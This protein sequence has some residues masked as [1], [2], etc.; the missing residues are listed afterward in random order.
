MMTRGRYQFSAQFTD[1]DGLNH[2][3]HAI[4]TMQ[5]VA[6]FFVGIEARKNSHAFDLEELQDLLLYNFNPVGPKG[7]S[8]RAYTFP[9][10]SSSSPQKGNSESGKI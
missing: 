9:P 6:N 8:Y 4:H 3:V 7:D 1:E 5:T 10:W 2:S